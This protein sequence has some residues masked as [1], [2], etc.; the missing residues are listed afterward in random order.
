VAE[1]LSD[2]VATLEAEP[3]AQKALSARIMEG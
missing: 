2:L 3:M 1:A